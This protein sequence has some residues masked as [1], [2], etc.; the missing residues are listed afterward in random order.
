MAS[1]KMLGCE[2]SIW[3]DFEDFLNNSTEPYLEY[4]PLVFHDKKIYNRIK[5]E[6]YKIEF[7]D[8]CIRC[9]RKK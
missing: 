1:M 7:L 3:N 6:G 2:D 4:V 8:T 9:W 5:K